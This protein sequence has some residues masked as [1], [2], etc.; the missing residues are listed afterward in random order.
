MVRSWGFVQ[1]IMALRVDGDSM[2]LSGPAGMLRPVCNISIPMAIVGVLLMPMPKLSLIEQ[3]GT[4]AS[5]A[6]GPMNTSYETLNGHLNLQRKHWDMGF[7][8]FNSINGG[9]RAGAAGA[10][11]P[12]GSANGEQYLGDVR[13]STEDWLDNWE[14]MAHA[15]YLQADFQAQGQLFP[16]NA[17][18]PIGSNGNLNFNP[19]ANNP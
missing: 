15:S 7:W 2:A 6:P 14:L 17:V 10:L 18:I 5:L 4:H 16:N 19:S 11:D 1:A 12:N 8:A 9:T 13:F 3:F